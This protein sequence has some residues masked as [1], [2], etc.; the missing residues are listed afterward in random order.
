MMRIAIYL[1]K[2]A[3][4]KIV[5]YFIFV[6]FV[7]IL[8]RLSRERIRRGSPGGAHFEK[9]DQNAKVCSWF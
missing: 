6:L 1:A 5:L 9:K 3:E 2:A 7:L 4:F 8:R